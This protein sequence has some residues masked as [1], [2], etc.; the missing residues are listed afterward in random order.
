MLE[1]DLG[2]DADIAADPAE[3]PDYR[4]SRPARIASN[5]LFACLAIAPFI[6]V[7]HA[8]VVMSAADAGADEG[9]PDFVGFCA[10]HAVLD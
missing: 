3:R 2:P 8:W 5:A 1:D 6:L 10:I 7:F 4:L 9:P